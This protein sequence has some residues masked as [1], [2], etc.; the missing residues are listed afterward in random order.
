MTKSKAILFGINYNRST[1]GKLNGCINDVK[2][3][4]AYLK[5]HLKYDKVKTYTDEYS[6]YHVCTHR[7]IYKLY[8]LAID[9]H[10]TD[11]RKVWIHFSGHGCSIKD[12]DNDEKDGMD[13]CIV[14]ADYKKAGV[15]TDDILN[16]IFKYFHKDTKIICI[17]DC[18]HSGTIADLT[19]KFVKGI[20]IRDNNNMKQCIADI[21]LISGCMDYQTSADA[22]NVRGNHEFSG[23][24]TSC[25][26]MTLEF[27][28]TSK[29]HNTLFIVNSLRQHLLNKKFSQRPQITSSKYIDEDTTL[30]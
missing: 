27:C 5:K 13:E 19:Y 2:N 26:L 4:G 12:Y 6:D 18:C 20:C 10:R 16:S 15:I 28:R 21:T 30:Y 14:P 11:L 29:K 24:M 22:Y 17:F 1:K 8:K 7:I 25:L 9:T 23:A 3:M